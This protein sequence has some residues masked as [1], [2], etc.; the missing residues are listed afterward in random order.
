[1][2]VTFTNVIKKLNRIEAV[3]NVIV[4]LATFVQLCRSDL[5]QRDQLSYY[6][7]KWKRT[8]KFKHKNCDKRCPYKKTFWAVHRRHLKSV[9]TYNIFWLNPYF[10]SERIKNLP[11]SLSSHGGLE[12]ER[13][14][15]K[16]HD[17][18]LVGSNP[19]WRQNK[20][21]CKKWSWLY[22]WT[23]IVM[24]IQLKE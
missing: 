5:V 3:K 4:I 9:F 14:L 17:S 6:I 23:N 18:T 16:L 13:L 11:E 22:Q 12:L 24:C 1:M 2:K 8:K 10:P 15:H 7:Q 21:V 19:V 20:N